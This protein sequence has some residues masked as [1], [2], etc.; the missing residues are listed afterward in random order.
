MLAGLIIPFFPHYISLVL[1]LLL[2]ILYALCYRKLMLLSE[3]V[4]PI[5][6]CSIS[7]IR[8]IKTSRWEKIVLGLL[9]AAGLVAMVAGIVK[10]IFFGELEHDVDYFYKMTNVGIWL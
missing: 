7:F 4:V 10:T 1:I 2:L 8:H 9:M 3:N 5:N 6:L